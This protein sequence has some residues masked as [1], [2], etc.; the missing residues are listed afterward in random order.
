MLD[1]NVHSIEF[2][3]WNPNHIAK[4]QAQPLLTSPA[5]S[6][7]PAPVNIYTDICITRVLILCFPHI[8]PPSPVQNS[9][10]KLMFVVTSHGIRNRECNLHRQCL[11]KCNFMSKPQKNACFTEWHHSGFLKSVCLLME[12][13]EIQPFLWR[14]HT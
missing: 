6:G 7:Q 2:C 14:N 8:F 5:C 3:N 1:S 11:D 10:I 9:G 4:P 13:H 12:E